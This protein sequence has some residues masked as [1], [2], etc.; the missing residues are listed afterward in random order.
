MTTPG[1]ATQTYLSLEFTRGDGDVTKEEL[2]DAS[3]RD[4]PLAVL[5]RF[6]DGELVAFSFHDRERLVIGDKN[7]FGDPTNES[8]TY[9]V[10]FAGKGGTVQA[11]KSVWDILVIPDISTDHVIVN[12]DE[13][14][15]DLL[16]RTERPAAPKAA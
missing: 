16:V 14:K 10:G 11:F 9:F 3:L 1:A 7:F 15:P 8:D 4:T 5:D 6:N 13:N 12:N 2:V